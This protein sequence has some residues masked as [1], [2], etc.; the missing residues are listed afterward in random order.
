MNKPSPPSESRRFDAQAIQT[1]REVAA[2]F[3]FFNAAATGKCEAQ[4]GSASILTSMLADAVDQ[5]H[6]D[7][8]TLADK[9]QQRADAFAAH[10]VWL[11]EASLLP[12]RSYVL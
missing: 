8:A 1:F 9:P 4:G 5:P 6:A 12:G 11:S 7:V 3:S 2:E 10:I